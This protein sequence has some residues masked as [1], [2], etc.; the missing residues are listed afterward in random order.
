MVHQTS[1]TV[2]LD[3]QMLMTR[4]VE[5]ESPTVASCVIVATC[6]KGG[7]TQARHRSPAGSAEPHPPLR[8][9]ISPRV[10]R[11]LLELD[12]FHVERITMACSNLSLLT[13]V[14]HLLGD[15]KDEELPSNTPHGKISSMAKLVRR[16]VRAVGLVTVFIARVTVLAIHKSSDMVRVRTS[17]KSPWAESFNELESAI[18]AKLKRRFERDN[19]E[20]LKGLI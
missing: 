11:F 15:G 10:F 5:V 19:D 6:I 4:R 20:K 18:S 9:P 2:Q 12:G 17:A 8:G 13:F 16:I 14:L 3:S 7:P 1:A